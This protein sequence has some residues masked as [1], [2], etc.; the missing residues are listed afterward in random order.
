MSSSEDGIA[1]TMIYNSF[2][3]LVINNVELAINNAELVINNAK[4]DIIMAEFAVNFSTVV[5][6]KHIRLTM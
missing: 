4:L 6:R 3:E 1:V 2:A 5:R